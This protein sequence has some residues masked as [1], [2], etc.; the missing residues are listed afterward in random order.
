MSCIACDKVRISAFVDSVDNMIPK[1]VPEIASH[2]ELSEEFKSHPHRFL[3]SSA[4]KG[5]TRE[6][7]LVGFNPFIPNGPQVG[8]ATVTKTDIS[9][10]RV[11]GIQVGGPDTTI[12]VSQSKVVAADAPETIGQ[13]RH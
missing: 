3:D 4:I 2:I 13:V 9:G 10:Y 12:K 6:G 5:C 7:M 1:H 11:I 8:H